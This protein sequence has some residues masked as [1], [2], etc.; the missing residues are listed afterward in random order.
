MD[1]SMLESSLLLKHMALGWIGG[2]SFEY[3]FF[4]GRYEEDQTRRQL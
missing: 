3:A 2:E 1:G 4:L